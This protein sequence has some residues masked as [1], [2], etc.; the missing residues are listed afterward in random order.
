MLFLNKTI[1]FSFL[2]ASLM[3]FQAQALNAMNDSCCSPDME[4][5]GQVAADPCDTCVAACK[6][7]VAATNSLSEQNGENAVRAHC[8]KACNDCIAACSKDDHCQQVANVHS[9]VTACTT[10]KQACNACIEDCNGTAQKVLDPSE[11]A[12]VEA[13]KTCVAACDD[14]IQ[15]CSR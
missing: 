4:D 1:K 7:C 15:A 5:R 12:C 14:C 3:I 8:V 10:C 13:C 2:A 9:C 6:N 11:A